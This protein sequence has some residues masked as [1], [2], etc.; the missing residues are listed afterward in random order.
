MREKN[1]PDKGNRR[2]CSLFSLQRNRRH[3]NSP[4]IRRCSFSTKAPRH[5]PTLLRSINNTK[6]P[7]QTT[8]MMVWMW[9]NHDQ[10]M[11]RILRCPPLQPTLA[12][13][14]ARK[15]SR[16]RSGQPL[17]CGLGILL[18]TTVPFVEITSWICVSSVRLIKHQPL[19][20]SAPS[21]GAYVI[22]PSTSTA[23]VVG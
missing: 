17:L 7:W 23:S 6:K 22:M 2:S 10:T 1:L 20:K 14:P 16:S 4:V 13:A 12:L 3:Q 21:L 8:K 5:F 11:Q 9:N 15:G 18:L 19:L